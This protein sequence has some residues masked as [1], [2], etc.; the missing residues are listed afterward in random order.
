M[1]EYFIL[2]SFE[3]P[4]LFISLDWKSWFIILS[5]ILFWFGLRVEGVSIRWCDKMEN[6]WRLE[7]FWSSFSSYQFGW[8]WDQLCWK[9]EREERDIWLKDWSSITLFY[10][11]LLFITH[12]Y[13]F[14][15]SYQNQIKLH[16]LSLNP[17]IYQMMK[18]KKK[19]K[20]K[21]KKKKRM[22]VGFKKERSTKITICVEVNNI[23]ELIL[24]VDFYELCEVFWLN[25]WL[26]EKTKT[27]Q[28]HFS[29]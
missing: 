3:F 13:I 10:H 5:L 18:K 7:W 14:R 23:I 21:K 11:V 4:F 27:C 19:M 6:I 25:C 28:T 1:I 22:G 26:E 8:K 20:M 17:M 16:H 29:L 24:W 9:I 12:I 2:S 15:R